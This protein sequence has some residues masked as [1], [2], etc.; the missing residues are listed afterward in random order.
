MELT[1]IRNIAIISIYLVLFGT[2]AQGKWSSLKTPDWFLKQFEKSIIARMPGGTSFGYW[3]IATV[4]A[5]LTFSFLTAGAML[6]LSPD[7]GLE[8]LRYSLIGA[9]FLFSFLCFG[10]RVTFDFQGSANM[11][12]Y[13]AASLL[14]LY[15]L[16]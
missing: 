4:E 13:F 6:F 9:M 2:A 3:M 5:A 8:I 16:G 15:V 11:F 7:L 1:L 14:C 10:L 12:V